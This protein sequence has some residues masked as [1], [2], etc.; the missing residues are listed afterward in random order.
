MFQAS[1]FGNSWNKENQYTSMI[2][3]LARLNGI[4]VDFVLVLEET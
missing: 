2:L 1:G 4:E 3:G